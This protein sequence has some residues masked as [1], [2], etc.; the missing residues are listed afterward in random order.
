VA[1]NAAARAD[2]GRPATLPLGSGY[3]Y[4]GNDGI[5]A[6]P[7]ESPL[8]P[9]RARLDQGDEPR[10]LAFR[11]GART[12]A[13]PTACADVHLSSGGSA[14]SNP[15][16]PETRSS[17]RLRKRLSALEPFLELL[18]VP[19]D[20]LLRLL[21]HNERHKQLADAVTLEVELDGHT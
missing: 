15:L 13:E 19:W 8:P 3:S 6:K 17:T 14:A 18:Q 5:V 12:G 21:P 9:R 1:G 7:P 10:L 11:V 16:W 2:A 20:F 4:E